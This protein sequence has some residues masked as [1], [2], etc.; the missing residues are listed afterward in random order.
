MQT[1]PAPQSASLEQGPVKQSSE[2]MQALPMPSSMD[3]VSI[4]QFLEGRGSGG[5]DH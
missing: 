2:L 4:T 5:G 3:A 1:K